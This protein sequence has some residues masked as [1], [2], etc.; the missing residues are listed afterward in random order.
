MYLKAGNKAQRMFVSM[1]NFSMHL[2]HAA[3]H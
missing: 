3:Q 1:R 2:Y